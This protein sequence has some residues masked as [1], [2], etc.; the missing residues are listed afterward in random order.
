MTPCWV[1]GFFRGLQQ[2][3]ACQEERLLRLWY[4]CNVN[5]VPDIA[6]VAQRSKNSHHPHPPP[7]QKMEVDVNVLLTTFSGHTGAAFLQHMGNSLLSECRTLKKNDTRSTC[8][9]CQ[10]KGHGKEMRSRLFKGQ[11]RGRSQTAGKFG[12]EHSPGQRVLLLCGCT[13]V[14]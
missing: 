3:G 12:V 2:G 5:N 10:S 13:V 9:Y 11:V 7:P 8:N 1:F 4:T 14:L 6:V